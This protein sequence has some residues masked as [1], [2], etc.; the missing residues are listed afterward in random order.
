MSRF[1]PHP[2]YKSLSWP[3]TI[4]TICLIIGFILS[5]FAGSAFMYYVIAL[6]TGIFFG[7]LWYNTRNTLQF[8]YFM[9][10]TLF[11]IGFVIGSLFTPYGNPR[12]TPFLTL[13]IYVIGIIAS[14][15]A[16]S[17]GYIKAIDF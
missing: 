12:I 10:I 3:E 1:I 5:F 7:R 15:Y 14:Y 9:I 4:A 16:H 11:M 2:S 17:K 13:F 6:L 8:K